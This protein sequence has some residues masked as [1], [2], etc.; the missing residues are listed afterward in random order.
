MFNDVVDEVE[1]AGDPDKD[2]AVVKGV[3]DAVVVVDATTLSSIFP[4]LV[5]TRRIMSGVEKSAGPRVSAT[6]AGGFLLSFLKCF[7]APA[8]IHLNTWKCNSIYFYYLLI[9]N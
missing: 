8:N 4:S 6:Y 9:S 1:T 3:A 5:P 7:F 2:T